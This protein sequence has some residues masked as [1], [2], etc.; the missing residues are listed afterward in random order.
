MR[1]KPTAGAFYKTSTQVEQRLGIIRRKLIQWYETSARDLPWR[2]TRD[3]YRIWVSEVML[4]QT[5]VQTV[6]PYYER[7]LEKFPTIAALAAAPEPELLAVWSGLGYYSRVR[8]ML[9]AARQMNG[10]AFPAVYDDIA[11][12]AGVGAYTA[13]AVASIAFGLPHAVVDGNV[14]RVLS[15]LRNDD[16]DISSVSTRRR[17]QE[18]AGEL[19]DRQRP[20]EFNQAMMELG[21]TVCLPRA[22]QCLLCPLLAEC[23]GRRAGRQEILPVKA[24]RAEPVY[25]DRAVLVV[26]RGS[27][28]LLRQR[29]ASERLMPSFWEMPEQGD[30][31]EAVEQPQVGRFRHSITHHNYSYAVIP[32]TLRG[33]P[34]GYRWATT[35][36]LVQLPLTTITKKALDVIQR[37]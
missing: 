3:P 14:L 23:E 15:R 19:L 10:G 16:S 36:D 18:F 27:S 21:A 34:K 30:L 25:L 32:A 24:R 12:L 17:F 2:R 31:P 37:G 1:S 29:A 22:P 9:K 5:R 33:K 28:V 4:Q 7:F 35:E 13:A 26:R 6:L 20:G 8:N 11:V